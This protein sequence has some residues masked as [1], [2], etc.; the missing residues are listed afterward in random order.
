[1]YLLINQFFKI[2]LFRSSPQDLPTSRFLATAALAVYS[3][4][5]LLIELSRTP[6]LKA[7]MMMT[8][9]LIV[10][11]GMSWII[12]WARQL[13]HRY[14][15]T[16]TAL[17]GCG[18]LLTLFAWPMLLLQ[19]TSGDEPNIF[20]LIIMWLW[21]FWLILVYSHIISRALSTSLFIGTGLTLIYIFISESVARTLFFQ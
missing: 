17:A 8:V 14:L 10:L 9:E 11:A 20:I 7:V 5:G 16:L 12:L 19:E 18:A 3:V 15:Q 2:C 21:F 1:M 13:D 4:L 6:L